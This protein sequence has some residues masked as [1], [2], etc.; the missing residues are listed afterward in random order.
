MMAQE[1]VAWDCSSA[2][3]PVNESKHPTAREASS[4]SGLSHMISKATTVWDFIFSLEDLFM[5]SPAA[6]DSH[7]SQSLGDRAMGTLQSISHSVNK[8]FATLSLKLVQ[9]D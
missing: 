9:N 8:F 3:A 7:P 5:T 6:G 2:S 1:P 4:L